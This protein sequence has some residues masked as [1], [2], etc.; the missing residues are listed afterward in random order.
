MVMND[1]ALLGGSREV[2]SF[3]PTKNVAS[4]IKDFFETSREQARLVIRERMPM[5]IL[6]L[7]KMLQVGGRGEGRASVVM[8]VV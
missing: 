6:R 3:L 7:N 4:E 5:T 1:T 8:V 2:V